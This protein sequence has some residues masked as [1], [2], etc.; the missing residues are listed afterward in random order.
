MNELL[1]IIRRKRRPLLEAA[2]EA[3]GS[4]KLAVVTAKVEPV[5]AVKPEPVETTVVEKPAE[6]AAVKKPEELVQAVVEKPIQPVMLDKLSDGAA[7]PKRIIRKS[8][9]K[10]SA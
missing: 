4:A 8:P 6:Q 9:L 7:L 1:P 3:D 2:A 10:P 5:Q